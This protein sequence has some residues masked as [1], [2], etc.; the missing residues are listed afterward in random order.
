MFVLILSNVAVLLA[1]MLMGFL[2]CK[3]KKAAVSHAKSLSGLL[4]YVLSPAMIINSF[5]QLE[6]SEE[7]IARIVKFFLATLIIQIL[8]FAV[9]FLFLRR[10]YEDAKYRILTVGAVLGNV[11]FFGMPVISGMFPDEPIVLCYSSVN[12]MS[13]NLI[14]FTIGVFL[15]TNDRKYVS[16]K[17]A[18]LNPTTLS[19]L[20]ALPLFIFNVQLP[21]IVESSV[22]VLAK[23]V[24]PMCMFIL[25]M[26][27]SAAKLKSL[28][29]RAFVYGTCALKLIAFPLFAFLCVRWLPFLDDTLKITVVVLAA[30]PSGAI[31][32]SLA[33]LHECE[34]ELS[35]NVVLLTTILSVVTMPA[36]TSALVAL[37]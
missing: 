31:I 1:Y 27:L 23:A 9:L 22:S 34:Q 3:A 5:L 33:E 29:S 24:T 35:A 19:M 30:A 13:M 16:I 32:E 18:I 6:Y 36:V 4:I 11:G 12:V 21:D 14:V 26:R 7:N 37:F 17:S 25:G 8:F 10:K 28:F 2:L 15:I 20:A